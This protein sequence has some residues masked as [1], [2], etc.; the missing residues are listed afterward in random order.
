MMFDYEKALQAANTVRMLSAE[1][2]QKAKSGHPGMPLGCADFAFTL[3]YKYM[4]H[5]P[6]NPNWLGRDRFILSAGHGSMLE[7]S[8]L[9]LF[10]YGLSMEE[11]PPV[12]SA[13]DSPPASAWRSPSATS[14]PRPGW[15]SPG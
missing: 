3:W 10:G 9:H 6:K 12:R 13:A 4:R 14:P 15:R 1:A 5:N 7:Y 8:L 2:I 11:S